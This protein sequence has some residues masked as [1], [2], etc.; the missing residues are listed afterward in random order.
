M[1]NVLIVELP[2]ESHIVGAFG[3]RPE[4]ELANLFV[5]E[6]V[7]RL[8]RGD[9]LEAWMV[10]SA[11]LKLA[12]L[13]DVGVHLE[14]LIPQVF[15]R[16]GH[17]FRCVASMIVQVRLLAVKSNSELVLLF[18]VDLV[19]STCDHIAWLDHRFQSLVGVVEI[20]LL[21]SAVEPIVKFAEDLLLKDT[22]DSGRDNDAPFERSLGFVNQQVE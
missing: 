16:N 15:R 3:R 13:L 9:V 5:L 10:D 20:R 17:A 12:D 21:N 18:V 1:D 2:G 8:L 22:G 6:L 14:V 4:K 11:R 19:D 7:Q